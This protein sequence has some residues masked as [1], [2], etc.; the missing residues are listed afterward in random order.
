[1]L[2]SALIPDNQ[3][4]KLKLEI[5]IPWLSTTTDLNY[6]DL[7]TCKLQQNLYTTA[8]P[9]SHCLLFQILNG[10]NLKWH[11]VSKMKWKF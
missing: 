6:I 9:K 1:M 7:D 3:G 2:D 11:E 4:L 8:K 5:R 10:I